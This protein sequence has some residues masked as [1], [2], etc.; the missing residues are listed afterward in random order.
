M[1]P[2]MSDL[3]CLNKEFMINKGQRI[4]GIRLYDGHTAEGCMYLSS[5]SSGKYCEDHS[6]R[7]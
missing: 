3:E 5:F 7:E 2:V 1:D 6:G 4:K